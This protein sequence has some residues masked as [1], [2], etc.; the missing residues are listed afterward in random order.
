[1]RDIWTSHL[2]GAAAV[3]GRGL[4][5]QELGLLSGYLALL[6]R[7]NQK[8]NLSGSREPEALAGHVLD[9]LALVPHLPES[10]RRLIDVGSGAGLPGA[11]LAAVRPALQV[12]ALEPVHK[13]HAFLATVRRELGL[14]NFHPLAQRVEDHRQAPGFAPYDVAVSRATFALP[15]WLAVGG[16]LVRD[17]GRVL[18]MEG[19]EQHELPAGASRHAYEL[20]GSDRRRAIIV[21]EPAAGTTPAV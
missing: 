1:M 3:L 20:P 10:A 6:S 7:W 9:C 13:K 19:I 15:D 11:I 18:A 4:D 17:G 16:S 8:I 2:S 12:A 14:A 21:W 5:T